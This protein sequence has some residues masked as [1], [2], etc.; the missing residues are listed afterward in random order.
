MPQRRPSWECALERAGDA[1]G[2]GIVG[3]VTQRRALLGDRVEEGF[4]LQTAAERD[5]GRH[6]GEKRRMDV[7]RPRYPLNS[8]CFDRGD[9]VG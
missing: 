1:R 5:V 2:I 3:A 9:R 8:G 6:V 4:A 7:A